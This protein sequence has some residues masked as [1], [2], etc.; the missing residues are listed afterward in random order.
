MR[1]EFRYF[2]FDKVIGSDTNNF[3]D[4]TKSIIDQ[5]PPGYLEVP[6]IEYCDSILNNFSEV[7]TDQDLQLMFDKHRQTKVV[8]I[9]IS[10]TDPMEPYVPITEWQSDD[11]PSPSEP[12]FMPYLY[13]LWAPLAQLQE[14]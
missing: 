1:K 4:F 5:Y 14:G 11:T 10:Y 9:F 8:E 6:H 7:K 2:C 12:A 13:I 3:K